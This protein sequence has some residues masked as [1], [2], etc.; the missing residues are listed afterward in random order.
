MVTIVAVSRQFGSGGARI[1]RA[2]A[3]RLGFQYADREILAAAARTL[4]C[5]ATE[6]EPMEERTASVWERIGTLFA[7][8]APDTPFLPPTLPAVTEAQLF[9]VEERIVRTIAAH[10]KAVIV[11][12]EPRISLGTPG[13]FCGSFCTRLCRTGSRGRC[14]NTASRIGRP[15]PL[16]FGSRMPLAPSSYERSPGRVGAM[17]RSTT[18]ALTRALSASNGSLTCS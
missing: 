6:L 14:R 10:G 9:A 1:G 7:L 2:V 4:N 18:S 5:E 11:G 16:S 12:A 3:Q 15:P 8:G 17:P 13:R